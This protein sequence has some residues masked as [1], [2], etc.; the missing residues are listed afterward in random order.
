MLQPNEKVILKLYI[1]QK[2]KSSLE[3]IRGLHKL[4]YNALNSNYSME[5]VDIL[6]NLDLALQDNIF[7]SPTLVKTHPKPP[8]KIVGRVLYND[9]L[10][11]L[12]L[13]G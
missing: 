10:R 8:K 3:T 4:F 1:N 5:I 9:L 12:N 2:T 6:T 11:D 7:A 13:H